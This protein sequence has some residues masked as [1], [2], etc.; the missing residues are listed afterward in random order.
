LKSQIP[1]NKKNAPKK[2]KDIAE[3]S[4]SKYVPP[5]RRQFSQRFVPTCH[6]CGKIGHIQSSCFKL[7]PCEH[8]HDNSYF[9]KSYEGLC[10]MMR[11]ALTR[12]NKLDKSHT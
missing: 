8:K 6:Y 12:L 7:K 2:E 5:H 9:K 1:W 4:L 11:V 3:S 10:N